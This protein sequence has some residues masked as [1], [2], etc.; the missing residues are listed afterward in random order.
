MI[1]GKVGSY[2][3]AMAIALSCLIAASQLPSLRANS[4]IVDALA[5]R[6]PA[7]AEFD[8]FRREFQL[9]QYEEV[10]LVRSDDLSRDET[11]RDFEDLVLELQLLDHVRQVISVFSLPTSDG[12]MAFLSRPEISALSTK[13]QLERLR[14]E[15]PFGA[16]FVDGGHTATLLYVILAHGADQDYLV[17]AIEELGASFSALQIELVGQAEIDRQ[18]AQSLL[19]D[20]LI[21]T[22]VAIVICIIASMVTLRSWRAAVCCSAAPLVGLLWYLACLSATGTEIDLFMT[23]I[24]SVLIV[25]GFTDSMHFFYASWEARRDL[26][27]GA[28]VRLAFRKVA[29]A[30]GLTSLTTAIAFAGFAVVGN[31][32]L[33]KLAFWGPAGLT[34][35]LLALG[36]VFPLTF[37]FLFA[38]ES[39]VSQPATYRQWL[40]L[41][42][43]VAQRPLTVCLATTV[44]FFGLLGFAGAAVPTFRLDEHIPRDGRLR[45]SIAFLR[46]AELGGA[47]VY[48]VAEDFDGQP[49]LSENDR[50][51]L[52]K[53]LLLASAGS[54]LPL[55]V[56]VFSAPESP[57]TSTSGAYRAIPLPMPLSSD[58]DSLLSAVGDVEARLREAGLAEETYLVGHSLLAAQLVPDIISDLRMAFYGALLA[59]TLL[60]WWVF[61]NLRHALLATLVSVMP[62]LSV[63]AILAISGNGLTLIGSLALTLAFGIAVDDSIHFMNRLRQENGSTAERISGALKVAG[64]PMIGTSVIL[65]AGL[66]ATAISSVPGIPIFG[67]LVG[68]AIL[69]ALLADLFLLP[70]LVRWTTRE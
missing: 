60:L 15:A 19:S 41:A 38:N 51:Q 70:G 18:V 39:P 69:L 11:F 30:A 52:E 4:E 45:E 28:A 46:D 6:S 20:N 16:R 36:L 42:G 59:V 62:I 22:T 43:V 2:L 14:Q 57:F 49:G 58:S 54:G 47:S 68:S 26:S 23:V 34:L 29:I 50:A 48:L 7:Y 17:A 8:L 12:E 44:L 24:P 56:T 64:P 65:V 61:G 55:P 3:V 35:E 40:R 13:S 5:S 1:S 32:A 37:A 53:T 25:L 9:G 31:E 67:L 63:E 10:I 21:V 66:A 33:S 27:A